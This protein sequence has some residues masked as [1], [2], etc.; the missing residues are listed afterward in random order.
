LGSAAPEQLLGYGLPETGLPLL[1][2]VEQ[3]GCV[4][5]LAEVSPFTNPL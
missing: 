3:V 2:V 5:N 1:A 4:V